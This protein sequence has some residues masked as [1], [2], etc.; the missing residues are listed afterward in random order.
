MS[1][2]SGRREIWLARSD[3]TDQRRITNFNGPDVG[4]LQWS[5]G[6][7]RLAFHARAQGHSDIFA[8]DCDPASMRCEN[9]KRLSAGMKAEVPSWSADGT[10][11]YFASDRTGQWEIWKQATSGG[12]LTQ[13]TRNGGYAARESRDRKWLY[14]SKIRGY[15]IWRIPAQDGGHEEVVIDPSCN[16]QQKGWALTPEEI[17]FTERAGEGRSAALRA[18]RLASKRM[19][20]ILGSIVGFADT[21]DHGLSVSPDSKWILYP[22]LEESGSNIM[23]A[24]SR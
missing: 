9:L 23:L 3:G 22:Q 21:R 20:L 12:K 13:V 8:L 16:V 11:L 5:P 2:R 10:F 4:D 15:G 14:F 17:V 19:R 7:R 24:E 6:G 1:D 18:F